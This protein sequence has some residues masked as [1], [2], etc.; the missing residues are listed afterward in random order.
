MND[1][2]RRDAAADEMVKGGS[3]HERAPLSGLWKVPFILMWLFIVG[4]LVS[5]FGGNW[6][7]GLYLVA[8]AVAC[9]VAYMVVR[10]K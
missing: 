5:F 8:G 4:A 9:N 6:R 1:M 3:A 2:E 10:R 7:W